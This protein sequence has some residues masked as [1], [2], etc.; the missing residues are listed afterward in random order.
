MIAQRIISSKN[1]TDE[2]YVVSQGNRV[3]GK[4]VHQLEA[5]LFYWNTIISPVKEGES[6][7]QQQAIQAIEEA[8]LHG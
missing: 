4:I 3:L 2:V 1:S 6:T 5:N 8:L 7:T